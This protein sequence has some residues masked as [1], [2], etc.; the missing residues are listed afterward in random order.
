MR[1]ND[2]YN[3]SEIVFR[4]QNTI[5]LPNVENKFIT[6]EMLLSPLYKKL[7]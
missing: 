5:E 4:N 3:Y 1:F 2:S 6:E 7:K